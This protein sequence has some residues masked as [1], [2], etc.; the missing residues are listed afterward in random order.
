[1][2][3]AAAENANQVPVDF[4]FGQYFGQQLEIEH[5]HVLFG[6]PGAVRLLGYRNR[7][8][9]ASFDDAVAVF[10]ADPSKNAAACTAFNYGSQ[11]ATPPHLCWRRKD[12]SEVGSG[13]DLEQFGAQ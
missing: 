7:V 3:G 8:F 4:R 12:N 13:I 5:D 9:S 6:L 1:A 11:N 10:Q 2:Q